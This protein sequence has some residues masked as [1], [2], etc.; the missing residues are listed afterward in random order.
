MYLLSRERRQVFTRDDSEYQHLHG[1]SRLDND[2]ECRGAKACIVRRA[3]RAAALAACVLART[4]GKCFL[5]AQA[6]HS[7]R[8]RMRHLSRQDWR[9]A[10]RASRSRS[11]NGMVHQL[12]PSKKREHRLLRLPSIGFRFLVSGFWFVVFESNQKLETRNQK[13]ET[14]IH[15]AS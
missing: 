10:P 4:R 7:S 11:D 5:H 13:P 3:Q 15:E 2:R 6:S 8:A 14:R 12:P 1:M 9:N